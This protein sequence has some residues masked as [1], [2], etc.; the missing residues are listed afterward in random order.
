M[1]VA[2]S[3]LVAQKFQEIVCDME[4]FVP[5]MGPMP[6]YLLQNHA[7][8]RISR[9]GIVVHWAMAERYQKKAFWSFLA[10]LQCQNTRGQGR[11]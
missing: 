10:G 5:G 7:Q 8:G 4:R 6:M 2:G 3:F 9:E 1:L 11:F